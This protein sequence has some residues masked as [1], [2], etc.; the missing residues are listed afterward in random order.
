MSIFKRTFDHPNLSY[1]W[2]CP[3]CDTAADRP[4]VLLPVMLEP[5]EGL[6]VRAK[7]V[8]ADYLEEGVREC[9]RE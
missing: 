4:V 9:L 5:H 6:T 2:L 8:H 1:N 3:I 7:Q